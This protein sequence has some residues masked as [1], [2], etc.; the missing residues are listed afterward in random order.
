MRRLHKEVAV[1]A[2]SIGLVMV[3]TG[4]LAATNSLWIVR[5]AV[6]VWPRRLTHV[7]A[8]RFQTSEFLVRYSGLMLAAAGLGVVLV[9]IV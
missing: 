5:Q 2:V 1:I 6:R 4:V 7:D 9:A 8:E 3:L